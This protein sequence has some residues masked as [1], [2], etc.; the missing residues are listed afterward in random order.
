MVLS[1]QN[2]HKCPRDFHMYGIPNHWI[3]KHNSR[4]IIVLCGVSDQVRALILFC[5]LPVARD[6]HAAA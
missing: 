5:L 6:D 4:G 1:W 2:G 3:Q